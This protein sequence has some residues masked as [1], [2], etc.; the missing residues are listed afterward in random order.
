MGG[1]KEAKKERARQRTR[2][3]KGKAVR[4]REGDRWMVEEKER[5]NIQ[6]GTHKRRQTETLQLQEH[7]FAET[8]KNRKGRFSWKDPVGQKSGTSMC[9]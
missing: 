2:G 4:N 7:V 9:V 8:M 5:G 1:N 6:E 3:T